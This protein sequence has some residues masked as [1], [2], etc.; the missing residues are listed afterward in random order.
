MYD[1]SQGR[2]MD[3][4]TILDIWNIVWEWHKREIL[5]LQTVENQEMDNRYHLLMEIKEGF[6]SGESGEI[7]RNSLC[8]MS[9]VIIGQ[10]NSIC[11]LQMYGGR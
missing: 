11:H 8:K 1:F 10:K 4:L 2:D 7:S 6:S 5:R 3:R 9:M